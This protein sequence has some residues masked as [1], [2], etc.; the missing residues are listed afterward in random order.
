MSQTADIQ[1]SVLAADTVY[2]NELTPVTAIPW[3]DKWTPILFNSIPVDYSPDHM[4]WDFGDGTRYTGL[5]AVH[6]YSW[7]GEYTVSL[8]IINDNGEPVTSTETATI[9]AQDLLPTQVEYH[10]LKD[11][12]DIPEGKHINPIQVDFILSWQNYNIPNRIS[13]E[14]SSETQHWM[15]EGKS[16]GHWMSGAQHPGTS[17]QPPIYTLN[18]YASG[19]ESIP[20]DIPRHNKNKYN[21]MRRDWA[22]YSAAPSLSAIPLTSIDV[23]LLD[24]LTGVSGDY[25]TYE[26]LYHKY[27]QGSGTFVQV[28]PTTPGAV[29]TGLS[30]NTTYYYRDDIAKCTSTREEP[31]IITTELDSLKLVDKDT[32]KKYNLPSVKYSNTQPLTISNVKPRKNPP[33]HL[34]ITSNGMNMFPINTNKWVNN[35]ITFMVTIQDEDHFNILDSSIFDYNF[36]IKLLDSTGNEHPGYVIT[37]LDEQSPGYFQG[38]LNCPTTGENVQLSA[39]LE[40]TQASGYSTDAIVG[41]LNTHRPLSGIVPEYGNLYKYMHHDTFTY[42][43]DLLDDPVTRTITGKYTHVET[44]GIISSGTITYPG[45]NLTS[46]PT[47][48][49]NDPTGTGG[50]LEAEYSPTTQEVSDVTIISG[51]VDYTSPTLTYYVNDDAEPPVIGLNIDNNRSTDITAVSLRSPTE[52]PSVWSLETGT[53]PR[54]LHI[55][56]TGNITTCIPLSGLDPATGPPVDI[57]LD[58]TKTPWICTQTDIIKVSK[59]DATVESVIPVTD[60]PLKIEIDQD[61]NIIPCYT[62]RIEKYIEVDGTYTLSDTYTVDS[63]NIIDMLL[64]YDDTLHVLTDADT[65]ERVSNNTFTFV[66]SVSLTTGSY[67]QL[68][69]TIDCNVYTVRD[70][71]YLVRVTDIEDTLL[72]FES[73][74]DLQCIAG[75]SRGM[76]WLTDD[77][78]RKI[79]FVDVVPKEKPSESSELYFMTL[80]HNIHADDL[81]YCKINF[82]Y[83]ADPDDGNG[84]AGHVI[85][86]TGDWTGFQWLQKYGYIPNQEITVQGTSDRFNLWPQPGLYNLRKHNEDHDHAAALKSYALQPWLKDQYILWDQTINAAVGNGQDDPSSLGKQI[87]ER[88]ANFIPNNNDI[89]DCNIDAIHNFTS[90]YDIDIQKY[91]LSYPPTL[92]RVMDLCSINHKRLYGEFDHST[93]TYDMYTDYTNKDTRENLGHEIDFMT[94]VLT[95]GETIIAYE[96]FSKIYTPV[97]VSYPTSGTIDAHG[98][99]ISKGLDTDVS[100]AETDTY[101]LSSYTGLWDWNLVTPVDVSGIELENYYCFFTRNDSVTANQVEGVLNWSDSQNTLTQTASSYNDWSGDT[102]QLDNI[103]EHQLRVGLDMFTPATVQEDGSTIYHAEPTK[104]KNISWNSAIG[105][106]AL[107]KLEG[108]E[109]IIHNDY[110]RMVWDYQGAQPHRFTYASETILRVIGDYIYAITFDGYGSILFSISANPIPRVIT[111][112]PCIPDLHLT[113]QRVNNWAVDRGILEPQFLSSGTLKRLYATMSTSVIQTL[114]ELLT[115]VTY[116]IALTGTGNVQ[117]NGAG[118]YQW[119]TDSAFSHETMNNETMQVTFTDS[120]PESITVSLNDGTEYIGEGSLKREGGDEQLIQNGNFSSITSTLY[121]LDEWKQASNLPGAIELNTLGW[122][123]G[124]N[125]YEI[126]TVFDG[127]VEPTIVEQLPEDR[128]KRRVLNFA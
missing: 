116:E 4:V 52:P 28:N 120:V 126:Y 49:I 81:S 16:P 56:E 34:A 88:I 65:I 25:N 107:V 59:T 40:F 41:W 125:D 78:N 93:E 121:T 35:E 72:D 111:D 123:Q 96:K 75:D 119:S 99:I 48:I 89:D 85:R 5:S 11:V 30:G 73:T 82:T 76:I 22:F 12:I 36:D 74:S 91:N 128:V 37:T 13:P 79:W 45:A 84:I 95:P 105:D 109:C 124:F 67:T 102:N 51:G 14:A 70:N 54:L 71:R 63:A 113:L 32:C 6:T 1:F 53:T 86:A 24:P 21:H 94:Y 112:D 10:E 101:P 104:K 117:F 31:V 33:D 64:M 66:N 20:L 68:T 7:P 23:S 57:K 9:T 17:I 122:L 110:G 26:L 47:I 43:P 29:F 80:S 27:D 115:D 39:S 44:N 106:T 118:G 18:L 98:N 58:S 92:K 55:Q 83:Y 61:N 77:A 127:A 100:L 42:S 50:S 60:P 62:N 69:T 103:I 114:P 90:I 15:N 46:P 87:F 2:T 108:I 38:T 97:T 3:E 19:S 8:T